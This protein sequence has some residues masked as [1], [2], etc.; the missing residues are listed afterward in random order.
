[1]GDSSM[2]AARQ[3]VVG[4]FGAGSAGQQAVARLRNRRFRHVQVRCVLDNDRRKW[5][6]RLDGLEVVR[7]TRRALMAVD[8]VLVASLYAGDIAAQLG[9]LG[10]GAKAVFS[11]N[12]LVSMRAPLPPLTRA[13]VAAMTPARLRAWT[14]G[15]VAQ[16][17]RSPWK[18]HVACTIASN[19]Y[20]AHATVLARSFLAQHPDARFVL[21]LADRIDPSLPS[22]SRLDS[23][24]TV[25]P[26]SSLGI[27]DFAPMAFQYTVVEFN[28]AI[29]PFLLEYLLRQDDCAAV[30][31]LDPDILVTAPLD[32]LFEE[33][34]RHDFVVTPHI[35]SPYRD[36]ARPTVVDLL[37]AGVF[38]LGFIGVSAR[39]ATRPFLAWWQERV[40]LDCI[41]APEDGIFVDQRWVDMLPA[42]SS[43]VFIE[44]AAGYN[45]AYWNLHERQLGRAGDRYSCNG[46]PLRF[47]HFSGA[48]FESAGT[49]LSRHQN[50]HELPR[51]G[52]LADLF[53]AYRHLLFQHGYDS[54]RSV[55][56]A[57]G[58]FDNGEPIPPLVRRIFRTHRDLGWRRPFDTGPRSFRR[59]LD[60]PDP[61]DR[62]L[63]R[64]EAETWRHRPE[65]R[66][67][68]PTVEG[69]HR[70]RYQ[71]FLRAHSH[72]VG[73]SPEVLGEGSVSRRRESKP[74]PRP[75]RPGVN[76][77][78]YLDTESGVGELARSFVHALR[79]CGRP[80]SLVNIAQP[81]LRRR[82]RSLEKG[83]REIPDHPVNF[84]A[85]NAEAV[86]GA[87]ATL[88]PRFFH[89]RYN[90]GY[91]VW[92]LDTFPTRWRG[93][94]DWFDEIWVPSRFCL[95]A[96][97]KV[98]PVPV[99]RVPPAIAC[100]PP[101]PWPR[102]R[103]GVRADAT[104]FGFVFDVNSHPERKNP[105]AVLDAY[106][107]AFDA[108][109]R[110]R[111]DTALV[112]KST[113]PASPKAALTDLR[114]RCR[115]V[116]ATLIEGYWPRASVLRL[117]AS[118]NAYVSLHR[119][120]GF[121]YTPAEAQAM[122]VPVIATAYSGTAD[123]VDVG[124]AFPVPW[125]ESRLSVSVGPYDRGMVWADP[126]VDVA[127]VHMRFV[128][129][130]RDGAAECG[131]RARAF[132]QAHYSPQV[133]GARVDARLRHIDAR[134]PVAGR[135]GELR[136]AR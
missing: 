102:E 121:G 134:L 47:F 112:I 107:R 123:F 21:C 85:V 36:D 79:A 122:G 135:T 32:G 56:Y 98:S 74:G 9:G 118:C 53:A 51:R 90:I 10:A 70:T 2:S 45:V 35:T 114:A 8:R 73:L 17:R 133:V 68:F 69:E 131:R 72:A 46:E 77:A 14:A 86:D 113:A 110:R 96:V 27:P 97:A 67:Q 54:L 20:L 65:V 29:K 39:P 120:E 11:T 5:G 50:R 130:D 92:E 91:W 84:L 18:G 55:P 116:G 93:A 126:A 78:G 38:N 23:R 43:S 13:S 4:V 49:T 58:R 129:D 103:I 57:F 31:Y 109:T 7:P 60:Q 94:F 61:R 48:V 81:W 132:M 88:G 28:T 108:R 3:L 19:N 34:G 22:P 40:A 83:P 105:W 106:E 95:D 104:M 12:E 63:T 26:A 101:T 136:H 16:P 6:T 99:V 59:W 24:I 89:G 100:P 87:A 80:H 124:H 15:V 64:L 66:T 30:L 76:V 127:A 119:A 41:V 117:I 111:G 52:P 1:M 37:K 128:H 44:R 62:G 75:A 71:L 82:D 125:R 33:L 25:I 115:K 42:F